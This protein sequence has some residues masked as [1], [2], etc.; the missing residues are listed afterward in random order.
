MSLAAAV[1]LDQ[2]NASRLWAKLPAEVRLLAARSLY[3]HRGSDDSSRREADATIAVGMRFRESAVRQLPVEKRAGYL[4]KGPA[5]SESLAASLL[6]ALH[7]EQRR[8]MLRSFLEALGIPNED[9]L[10]TDDDALTPQ[11]AESLAKAATRLFE[12]FPADEVELYL[13]T[14]LALDPDNWG[15]LEPVLRERG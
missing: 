3:A 1:P 9:G 11:A 8:P 10:I 5:P 2:L 7:L 13:L 15:G 12:S 4:A 14:L 6:L